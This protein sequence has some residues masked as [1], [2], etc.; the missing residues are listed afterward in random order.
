MF[1]GGAEAAVDAAAK[2]MIEAVGR[3]RMAIPSDLQS[4]GC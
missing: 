1:V 2:I 4:S 3:A